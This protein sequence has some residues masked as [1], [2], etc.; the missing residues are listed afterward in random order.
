MSSVVDKGKVIGRQDCPEVGLLAD[1]NQVTTF[2]ILAV[3]EIMSAIMMVDRIIR[4]P[5][6]GLFKDS[7]NFKKSYKINQSGCVKI[8][9]ANRE[10]S[11]ERIWEKYSKKRQRF[12]KY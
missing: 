6:G 1:G 10:I 7:R 11:T 8:K 9:P 3:F 5:G 4:L 12:G 2:R